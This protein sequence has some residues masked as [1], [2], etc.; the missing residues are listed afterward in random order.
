MTDTR[1]LM[2]Y[3]DIV[4]VVRRLTLGVRGTL[5]KKAGESQYTHSRS[6]EI[7]SQDQ[8]SIRRIYHF[9]L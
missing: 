9:I 4:G 3:S 1:V 8:V 5:Y 6:L 7:A 2:L